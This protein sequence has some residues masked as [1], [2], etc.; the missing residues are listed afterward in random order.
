MLQSTNK[1]VPRGFHRGRQLKMK[2]LC[3]LGEDWDSRRPAQSICTS[4]NDMPPSTS[5]VPINACPITN[6]LLHARPPAT[7]VCHLPGHLTS[8]LSGSS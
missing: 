5:D 3:S 4:G 7:C 6:P 1:A 8:W 2:A